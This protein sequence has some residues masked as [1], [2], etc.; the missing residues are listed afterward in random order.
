MEPTPP[1]HEARQPRRAVPDDAPELVRLRRLM[2]DSMA[3]DTGAPGW[4]E[5]AEAHLA[6]PSPATTS[7]GSSSTARTGGS[8]PSGVIEFQSRIP[9][10]FNPSGRTA[11]ISTM[12]TDVRW[13]GRGL[14]RAVLAGLL[15]EARRR[16][17]RRI[18]LHAT[19]AG[20]A[21][22]ESV[23]FVPRD[24]GLE[25]RLDLGGADGLISASGGR[26]SRRPRCRSARAG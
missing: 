23:G 12:S 13:R 14:A 19:P 10:P 5:S 3:I 21:L 22:Y 26:G 1:D 25:M 2:F 8:Q 15:A 16:G 24:A 11:Y 18:E 6:P 7:W 20:A 4:A 9:S 17:V